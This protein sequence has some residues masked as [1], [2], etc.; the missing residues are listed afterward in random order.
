MSELFI[1]YT[2][3]IIIFILSGGLIIL[4]QYLFNTLEKNNLYQKN[5][6]STKKDIVN[7]SQHMLDEAREKAQ[8][9]INVANTK[10]YEI[11][12]QTKILEAQTTQSSNEITAQLLTA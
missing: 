2:L 8:E 3:L 1:L 9:I 5:M 10:A 11:I 4:I 12:S 6:E 7:H